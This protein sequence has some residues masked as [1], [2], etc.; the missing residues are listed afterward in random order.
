MERMKGGKE[1]DIWR[2]S[3]VRFAVYANEVGESFRHVVP[4]LVAPSYVLL[5][6]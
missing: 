4:R 5:S 2:D 3:V 1:K 6:V